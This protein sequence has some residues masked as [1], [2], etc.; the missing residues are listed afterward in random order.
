MLS[1]DFP[2]HLSENHQGIAKLFEDPE[3]K[4]LMI[5]TN[6]AKSQNKK[7]Q[8]LN[9]GTSNQSRVRSSAYDAKYLSIDGQVI[10]SDLLKSL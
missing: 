10:N 7:R 3:E 6:I 9:S 5:Q 8:R 4:Q 2:Y 1:P